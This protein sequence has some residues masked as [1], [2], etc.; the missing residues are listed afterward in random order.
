MP[1]VNYYNVIS[2]KPFELEIIFPFVELSVYGIWTAI[3][4]EPIQPIPKMSGN[5]ELLTNKLLAR[6]GKREDKMG[7]SLSRTLIKYRL[8]RYLQIFWSEH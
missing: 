2:S 5:L 1:V 3:L 7:D 8:R 4:A 6:V